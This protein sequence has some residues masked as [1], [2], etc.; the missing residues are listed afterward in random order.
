MA[1]VVRKRYKI[2]TGSGSRD[3]IFALSSGALPAAI[4]VVR[5]TGPAAFTAGAALAGSIPPARQA[6]LRRL[7]DRSGHALDDALVIAFPGPASATGEDLLE[8]HLHGGRAVVHAVLAALGGESG[9]R[10]AEAGEFTRRALGNGR[11]DLAEAEGLADL[12]AAES[13]LA[14]RAALASAEGG[15]SRATQGWIARLLTLSARAEAQID[16]ADE[17]DLPA[18]EAELTR[19]RHDAAALAND[20]AEVLARPAIER[21]RDGFRVVLAGPPNAGKSSLI[22]ALVEREVAIA[23]PIPGTTRDRLEAPVLRDGVGYL[24]TD[25]AGLRADAQDAVEA[26]GIARANDAI[27]SADLVIWLGDD[28]PPDPAMLAVHVRCD[29]PERTAGVTGRLSVS[30]RTNVGVQDLWKKIASH[31]ASLLPLGDLIA[32]NGR[33]RGLLDKAVSE[34]R[35]DDRGDPILLAE[36]LRLARVALDQIAGTA[37]LDDVLDDLFG[38]FCIGK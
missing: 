17:D 6:A 33:Q 34:L 29:E 24:L 3:T 37:A 18:E 4:G 30:A 1:Q 15:V 27:A 23:T 19:V 7:R 31:C 10:P 36:S 20:L 28:M 16:F 12:L 14:R 25:T 38:R 35:A 26:I 8:L 5:I 22:N 11:I 13:E 21:L 32:F 2:L 9:L